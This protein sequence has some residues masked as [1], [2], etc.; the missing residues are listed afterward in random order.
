METSSDSLDENS[1]INNT[2]NTASDTIGNGTYITP[3]II[4][5]ENFNSSVETINNEA[6][7]PS[8]GPS[9]EPSTNSVVDVAEE[10]LPLAENSVSNPIIVDVSTIPIEI[11]PSNP[12][13]ELIP[14]PSPSSL[15]AGGCDN[16]LFCDGIETCLGDLCVQGTPVICNDM[17]RCTDDF[18]DENID[19]CV[20]ISNSTCPYNP[21]TPPNFI[22]AVIGDLGVNPN[23]A[24]TL[25]LIR[26]EGAQMVLH[27]G[28]LGYGQ[29][30]SAQSAFD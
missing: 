3:V 21:N 19:S 11:T 1:N 7:G 20:F 29:E 27:A 26:D 2:D 17:D 25:M 6:N 10:T 14:G 30:G 4:S 8:I 15:C 24:A 13:R 28:D 16:G 9:I 23:A 12:V 18:C 22:I 5:D